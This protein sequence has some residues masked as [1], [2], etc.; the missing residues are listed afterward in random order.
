MTRKTW[1][2]LFN[3]LQYAFLIA[4]TVAVLTFQFVPS[5]YCVLTAISCY[6]AGFFVMSVRAIFNLIE[7]IV[8]IK[9]VTNEKSSLVTN[10][11][12]EV[13][14][15]KAELGH[16]IMSSIIWTALFA[17]ALAILILYPKVI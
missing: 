6:V 15:S 12:K 16:A 8:S 10:N 17:F 2:Y 14:N 7:L 5:V 11:S 9:R 4:A 13:L 1:I 3:C